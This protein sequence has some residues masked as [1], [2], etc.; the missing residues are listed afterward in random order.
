VSTWAPAY[1]ISKTALNMLTEQF[2]GRCPES[3]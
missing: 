3:P 2:S 1:S